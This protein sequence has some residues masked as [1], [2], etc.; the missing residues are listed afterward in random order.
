MAFPV[1]D[2][3]GGWRYK[4]LNPYVGVSLGLNFFRPYDHKNVAMLN[5]FVGSD[6]V[7]NEQVNLALQVTFYD[8]AYN[9][10][11]SQV[12]WIYLAEDVPNEKKYGMVG[13]SLGMS[14][15]FVKTRKKGKHNLGTGGE[16]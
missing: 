12:D 8:V 2:V 6:F 1:V 7:V 3:A 11:G 16:K 4:W 5:P 15:D 9:M 10:Y 13:L 14:Y